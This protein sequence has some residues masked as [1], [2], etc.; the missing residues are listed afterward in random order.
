MKI[1]TKLTLSVSVAAFLLVGTIVALNVRHAFQSQQEM[2]DVFIGAANKSSLANR[3]YV[4]DIT[5]RKAEMLAYSL[6]QTA[7]GLIL[8]YDFD[9]LQLLADANQKDPDIARIVFFDENGKPLN[10]AVDQ[11]EIALTIKQAIAMDEQQLGHLEM[12]IDLAALE[13]KTE[14]MATEIALLKQQVEQKRAEQNRSLLATT[15]VVSVAGLSVLMGI[16]FF[17]S[18]SILKPLK[19][20]VAVLGELSEGDGDLTRRLNIAARDETGQ[21]ALSFNRFVDKLHGIISEVKKSATAVSESAGNLSVITDSTSAGVDQQRQQTEQA[22]TA[23]TQMA[24]TIQEVAKSAEQAAAAAVT[25][26][27]KANEGRIVVG[28]T[29]DAITEL[30]DDVEAT[31]QVMRKL[32]SDSEN[33]G[34][35]L[36]VI[37]GIA[38]QTNLLALNAAIEAARAGE[39]GRGFAVVADEVRTLAQR[40]QKSTDEI[41]QMIESLQNEANRA[42]AAAEQ[43]RDRA[44]HTV[45][46][47]R[48]AGQALDTIIE[49]IET[50]NDMNAQ[51]ASA[52]EEQSVVAEEIAERV[53]TIQGISEQTAAGSADTA[54]AST[55]LNL[56]SDQLLNIVGQFHLEQETVTESDG[57]SVTVAQVS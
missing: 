28:D 37:K 48:Q 2:V 21:L 52:S 39:Q 56:L 10:Q 13:K 19:Q 49:G 40:T 8:N 14:E 18:F 44:K 46:Q 7:S 3:A 43:G 12:G 29:V 42:A 33:I 53:V 20:I 17:T 27:S 11:G 54:S 47:A 5:K 41:G 55:R 1:T 22:A 4:E 51:I 26:N 36:D 38:E 23:V 24:S 35:V 25:S 30:S 31:S 45:A 9:T 34:T 6:A 16:A 57:Q 15:V 32:K 50:I